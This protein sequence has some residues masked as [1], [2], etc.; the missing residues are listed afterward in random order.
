[1]EIP[2]SPT[3]NFDTN[4]DFTVAL[5]VLA[6]PNQTDTTFPDNAIV[7]KWS[8]T[9]GYPYV[10]RYQRID[11]VRGARYDGTTFAAIDGPTGF[12]GA[13][14]HVAFVKRDSDLEL[15]IDGA[16]NGTKPDTTTGTTLNDSPLYLGSRGGTNLFFAGALDDVRIYDNALSAADIEQLATLVPEPHLGLAALAALAALIGSR[17]RSVRSW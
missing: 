7:A 16:L 2:N 11:Y 14:H 12:A 4:E 9:D 3:I 8:G 1:M 5:W 13:F 10:V 15:W 17:R 6:D